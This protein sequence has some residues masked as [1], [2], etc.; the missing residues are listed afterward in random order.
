VK[1]VFDTADSIK[2]RYPTHTN[3]LVVDRA[4]AAA[5]EVFVTVLE[6]GEAPPLH[7]HDDTEQVFFILEGI[8]KLVIGSD[9][10]SFPVQPGQVVRVPPSTPHRIFCEGTTALKYLVV[11]CFVASRPKDEPTWESHVQVMCK[12]NGWDIRKVRPEPKVSS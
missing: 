4:D 2:Y 11:D 7:Q 8:G 1:Y 6:P 12:N 5:S 3:E 9:L 10:R